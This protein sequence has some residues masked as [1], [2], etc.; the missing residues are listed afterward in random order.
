MTETI[1][2]KVA[3]NELAVTQ[4]DDVLRVQIAAAGINP[5]GAIKPAVPDSLGIVPTLRF[6]AG[7]DMVA[8][9]SLAIPDKTDKTK[10][11][12]CR[13][14]WGEISGSGNVAYNILYKWITQ[15]TVLDGPADGTLSDVV[16]V[17]VIP[18]GYTFTT[19]TVPAPATT[20]RVLEIQIERNGAN[21]L[22][23]AA[24]AVHVI[25]ILFDFT[26]GVTP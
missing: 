16:A 8:G 14:G 7:V 17:N 1:E 23:T 9:V 13:V 3:N 12:E 10:D 11:V 19:I 2:L 6:D 20:D 4:E 26:A 18:K 25:G 24:G 15:D 22:D 21:V 5:V